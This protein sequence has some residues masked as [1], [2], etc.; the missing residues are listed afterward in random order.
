MR[1][2]PALLAGLGAFALYGTTLAPGRTWAHG[3][4]DGGDLLAAALVRGVPHPTGYP[5]YQLVL[6]A[7]IAIFGGDPAR[8][9]AWLS[10]ICAALAAALLADL[11]QRMIAALDARALTTFEALQ[12][13]EVFGQPAVGPNRNVPLLPRVSWPADVASTLAALAWA[14]APAVWGQ[15]TITEVY[16][17]N[18]LAS[19]ALLWLAWRW[20]EGGSSPALCAAG[21]VLGLGLGNHLTLALA[22]PGLAVWVWKKRKRVARA[23]R[24]VARACA[25]TLLGLLVYAY[26]PLAAAGRPPVNWGDPI[27]LERFLWTVSGRLYAGLAFGLPPAD[28]PARLLGWT[29]EAMWQFGGPWGALLALTGLWRLQARNRAWWCATL[30]VFGAFTIYG[31]G[32]NTTDS[33]VYLVPAWTA[34]ALWIAVAIHWVLGRLPGTAWQ[35]ALAVVLLAALPAA[36]LVRNWSTHDLRNDREARDFLSAALAE[37]EEG[38]LILTSGDRSTFALWYG[39]YGLRRRSDLAVLNV[40]LHG[41]DWYDATFARVHGDLLPRATP[42]EESLVALA[43]RRPVY[44]ADDLGLALPGIVEERTGVL[45]RLRPAP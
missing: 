32:Y 36:S 28:L 44:R 14:A 37:A 10:A 38:S 22:L 20:A 41:Y 2:W 21:L 9:G 29:G 16:A 11:A 5:T 34:A 12:T 18:A 6:R 26:L 35:A 17:L 3:G 15:A 25:C 13:S 45:V 33:V 39:V 40:N 23:G 31:I 27:T 24:D 43:A 4:A 7:A 30:L 42:L 8:A 19:V 1:R